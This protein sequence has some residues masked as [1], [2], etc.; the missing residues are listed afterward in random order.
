MRLMTHNERQPKLS[1]SGM[2]DWQ[3]PRAWRIAVLCIVAAIPLR[4]V[5]AHYSPRT[6]W[7]SLI[8]FGTRFFPVAIPEMKACQP[9][10]LDGYGYDGQFYCQVAIDPTLRNPHLKDS[11]DSPAY[12]STRILMP[13]LAH[14]VGLG[15]PCRIIQVYAVL[16]LV[17]WFALLLGMVRYLRPQTVRD[18]VCVAAAALTSGIL[19]SLARSLTDLPA[20]TLAFYSAVFSGSTAV[21]LMALALLTKETYVLSLPRLLE[22]GLAD[23]HTTRTTAMR[24]GLAVAPLAVWYFYAH[25]H[26]GFSRSDGPNVSWPGLGVADYLWRAWHHW[27]PKRIL[28]PRLIQELLAPISLLVQIAYMLWHRAPA[29]P[30]WRM[31]IGFA[32]SFLLLSPDVF[33]DQYSF[34]RD[35]IPLTLAFNI[36]L[37]RDK[38]STFLLWFTAGNIGLLSG[39]RETMLFL[40]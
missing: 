28:S 16:N 2:L 4:L 24:L 12:R 32:L 11:L 5:L 26:F 27:Y 29:S 10:L 40:N 25:L 14:V 31:G 23:R 30:Y 15:N 37:M 1:V 22:P 8:L 36:E 6:G 7:S 17:F 20:A 9:S 21:A 39:V 13:A 3:L 18:H 35:A 19:F 33:I 34:C 38:R